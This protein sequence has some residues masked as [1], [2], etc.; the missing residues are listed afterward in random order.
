MKIF[1][2]NV[3]IGI[4]IYIIYMYRISDMISEAIKEEEKRGRGVGGI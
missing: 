2:Q 4:Y 3:F 1:S